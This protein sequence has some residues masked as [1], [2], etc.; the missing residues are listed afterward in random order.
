MESEV[1]A[2]TS[3]EGQGK[4][5]PWERGEEMTYRMFQPGIEDDDKAGRS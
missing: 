5:I 4:S 2:A 1:R 3:Q